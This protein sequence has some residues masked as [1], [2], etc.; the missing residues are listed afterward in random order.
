MN[1]DAASRDVVIVTG[2]GGFIG[3]A[4]TGRLAGR[5]AVVV[6]D[7]HEP[8]NLPASA[9]FVPIDLASDKAVREAMRAV[10]E[11]HGQR[12]ASV[13]HLAAYFD[14]TG[15]PSPK[16]E[17]ITVRGTERLLRELQGFEVGQF[18]FASTMLVHRATGPAERIDETHPLDPK[19]P[20]RASK[21][22][23]ERLIHEQR[24]GI[25]VVYLRPAGVYDNLCRNAFLAH[26]IARINERSLKGHLYSG[27]PGAGQSF[28]HLDDFAEAVSLIV[29][30][31]KELPPELPL[32]LGEGDVINYEEL[33][34]AIGRLLHGEEWETWSLPKPLAKAGPGSKR[35]FWARIPSSAPGWWT[36][37]ATATNSTPAAPVT[38]SGGR[39]DAACAGHYPRSSPR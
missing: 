9:A 26:Q 32:L 30:R 7:R 1:Q 33:Q 27:H 12:I 11:R 20:Y 13:I 18:I 34:R 17:Q 15:E 35:R 22:E 8:E 5:Y 25:P 31:R 19:L 23:T 2:G 4:I 38:C 24:G 21:I 14:L 29:G 36:S 39:P 6:L 37:P 3:R 16:Y 28:L 10:R